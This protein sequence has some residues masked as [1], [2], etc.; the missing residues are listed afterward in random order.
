MVEKKEIEKRR[1]VERKIKVI[2]KSERDEQKISIEKKFD[3]EVEVDREKVGKMVLQRFYK[4]LKVFGK[5]KSERMPMR[6]PWVLS[7][8]NEC[9]QRSPQVDVQEELDG[10]LC[11]IA[12]LL[13]LLLQWLYPRVP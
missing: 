8:D 4:Q 13:I 3:N 5:A 12:A 11:W 2:G 10:V 9:P 6:K 7:I 1:K